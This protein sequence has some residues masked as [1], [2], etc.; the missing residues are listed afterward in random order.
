MNDFNLLVLHYTCTYKPEKIYPFQ[1][2]FYYWVDPDTKNTVRCF[3]EFPTAYLRYMISRLQGYVQ[4]DDTHFQ[5]TDGN[6]GVGL[7][8]DGSQCAVEFFRNK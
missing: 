5:S 7:S 3:V 4:V 8:R 2:S 6:I 1:V